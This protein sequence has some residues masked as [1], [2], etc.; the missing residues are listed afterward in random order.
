MIDDNFSKFKSAVELLS[1][2][3]Q[4]LDATNP[5]ENYREILEYSKKCVSFLEDLC[6]TSNQP[7]NFLSH[8][9]LKTI[10]FFM[11][12]K[13]IDEYFF[14]TT[15]RQSPSIARFSPIPF[16][17]ERLSRPNSRLNTPSPS[18]FLDSN[19]YKKNKLVLAKYWKNFY[20]IAADDQDVSDLLKPYQSLIPQEQLK[21]LKFS[22]YANHLEQL[23]DQLDSETSSVSTNSPHP[24]R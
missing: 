15:P 19:Q 22:D 8:N 1:I 14:S 21:F 20:Q 13:K 10:H 18:P 24:T 9:I 7:E 17:I 16:F 2:N 11:L 23:C 5:D 3:V 4:C 12:L 6:L